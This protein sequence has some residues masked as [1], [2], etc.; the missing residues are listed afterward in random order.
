[1][2]LL[3]YIDGQPDLSGGQSVAWVIL[4]CAMLLAGCA[5]VGPVQVTPPALH[6]PGVVAQIADV[7]VLAVSP[8]MDAFLE[9]H[10]L[11]HRSL[12][13]RLYLLT[14]GVMSKGV[15][16]FE[17]DETSTLTAAEAFSRRSGN[18]ISHASMLIALARRAG[19]NAHYQ[20]VA[21]QPEWS[22]REDTVLINKHIDVLVGGAHVS[23][24]VDISGRATDPKAHRRMLSDADGK[25]IYFNNLGAV[26]LVENDL[27]AAYGYILRAIESSPQVPDSWVNLG[28]VF[29]RNNQL[30]EAEL[31]HRTA[32]RIDPNEISAMNN[33]YG[34]YLHQKRFDEAEK[35]QRKVDRHRRRNPYY[36]L[37]LSNEA[38]DQSRLE[39]SVRL[40]KR[41]TRLKGDDHQLYFAL[42]RAQYRLGDRAAAERSLLRARDL[43][44]EE[45]GLSL[46]Q[47]MEQE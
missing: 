20:E 21:I 9:R 24:H 42:A 16:G 41:A 19:L 36:L 4:S 31:S 27:P 7:D 34:I 47:L 22:S 18:C 12:E 29:R 15:L 40:L 30:A 8:E 32:L 43:A 14:L 35:L 38:L 11:P 44:P 5:S 46:D 37:M 17:Y 28:V 3:R 13:R 33:L 2:K 45:Y 25:A 10:I 23:L 6:P 26:K 39:D 1:M